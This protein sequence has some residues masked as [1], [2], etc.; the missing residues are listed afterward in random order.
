MRKAIPEVLKTLYERNA[1]GVCAQMGER[2]NVPTSKIRLLFIYASFFTAGSP[3]I[4]YFVMVGLM[5]FRKN[6]QRHRANIW[7]F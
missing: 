5:E 2:L 4:V 1:F 6:M 7:D 3:L